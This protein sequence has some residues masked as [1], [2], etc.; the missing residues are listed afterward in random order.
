LSRS[1]SDVRIAGRAGATLALL[2]SVTL[3]G[4]AH[5]QSRDLRS[6]VSSEISVS[7]DEASLRIGYGQDREDTWVVRQ[8]RLFANGQ[9]IGEVERN[10]ALDRAWRN[11]L[12]EAMELENPALAELLVDWDAPE[13]GNRERDQVAASL[14]RM[15]E[16]ALAGQVAANAGIAAQ[17]ADES[18]EAVEA[19]LSD[20][21]SRLVE[22][23]SELQ[24]RVERYEIEDRIV[25]PN[26]NI[27]VPARRGGFGGPFRHF[28]GGLSGIFSDL[29]LYAVLFGIA[30]AT[31]FFGGRK[32]IEGV[33]DTARAA[34][35]RSL[36][37]GLAA[38]FLVVP[39]FILGIVALL[40]SIVGIPALLL[41]VPLFPIAVCAAV[42]LG[43]IAAAHAAGEALAERHFYA[44]DWFQRGNSYYFI[45]TGL[46]LLLSLFVA[47]H[48]VQMAGPWLGFLRS[49]L[50]GLGSVLTAT[51]LSI[52]FGAVLLSRA[53]TRPMRP[54]RNPASE[55]DIYAEAT[56][57]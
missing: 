21:M 47:S 9:P 15:L 28:F 6:I 52:G 53:G 23:I 16:S 38:A 12:N 50:V 25:I 10:G 51:V 24:Q 27:D 30:F 4:L 37:V 54:K 41:W 20:S 31:I 40:I 56:N 18:E 32:Y 44:A 43:Y 36:L 1:V 13:S 26:V 42:L 46:G 2:L 22:R 17:V 3:P 11:L 7:R 34:P 49:I 45:L 35:T 14:D 19:E 55:P 8:G 5:A 39:A 57:V 48:V 33:A 29:I